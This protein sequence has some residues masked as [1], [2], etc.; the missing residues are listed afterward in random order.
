M[1]TCY[2]Y[3]L[4]IASNFLANSSYK[5]VL[6]IG[7][8]K[9]SAF[10]NW[11]DRTTCVIFADGAGASLVMQSDGESKL[12]FNDWVFHKVDNGLSQSDILIL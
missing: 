8:E 12:T 5:N 2:I 1:I 6:I 10:I 9:L 3:S 11:E 4:V 7:A